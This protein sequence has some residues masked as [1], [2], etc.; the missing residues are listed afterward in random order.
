[1]SRYLK[2]AGKK[3]NNI[4]LGA[5]SIQ[6]IMQIQV[7]M[8]NHRLETSI[9]ASCISMTDLLIDRFTPALANKSSQST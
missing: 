8:L 9:F 5:R 6:A 3:W 2:N 4:Q 7:L 1:M